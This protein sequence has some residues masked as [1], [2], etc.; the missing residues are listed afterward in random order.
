M[1]KGGGAM[2]RPELFHEMYGRYFKIVSRLLKECE[3]KGALTFSEIREISS[4]M[5]YDQTGMI[6]PDLVTKGTIGFRNKPPVQ[7]PSIFDK[8]NGKFAA[9]IKHHIRPLSCCRL[10]RPKD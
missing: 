1:A 8:I 5:G 7:R 9:G 10:E 4:N 2:A 3:D 6:L